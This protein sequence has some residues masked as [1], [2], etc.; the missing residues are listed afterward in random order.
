ME[1]LLGQP[2]PAA[3]TQCI[4][5]ITPHLEPPKEQQEREDGEK[6]RIMV[7]QK[8]KECVDR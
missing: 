4:S 7:L 3:M 2:P 5:S 1:M 8:G 6:R